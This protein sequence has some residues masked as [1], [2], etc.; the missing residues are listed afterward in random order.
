ME[1]WWRPARGPFVAYMRF[2]RD[3]PGD[4]A[5]GRVALMVILSSSDGPGVS[6]WFRAAWPASRKIFLEKATGHS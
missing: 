2:G 1:S 3:G 5:A 6:T 4:F